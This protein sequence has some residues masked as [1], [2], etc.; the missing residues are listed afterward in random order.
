MVN[1][2]SFLES[3]YYKEIKSILEISGELG[4]KEGVDV[5]AVGGIVRDL[6]MGVKSNDIDI[7]VVGDGID[8]AK[9]I[10]NKLKRKK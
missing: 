4:Q 6:I 1:I 5:F 2:K 7:M 3:T 9:K 8:F 10:A